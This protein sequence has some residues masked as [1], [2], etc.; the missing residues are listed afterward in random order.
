MPQEPQ[1][2]CSDW[3]IKRVNWVRVPIITFILSEIRL[4][5]MRHTSVASASAGPNTNIPQTLSIIN[6]IPR[7]HFIHWRFHCET[8]SPCNSCTAQW[9]GTTPIYILYLYK[10]CVCVCVCAVHISCNFHTRTGKRHSKDTYPVSLVQ[11]FVWH[12]VGVLQTALLCT[13]SQ[14]E[15]A[16]KLALENADVE[17]LHRLL[18]LYT[19]LRRP[20]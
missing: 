15:I 2:F 17:Y 13:H 12:L 16:R 18:D 9:I 14:K 11:G 8:L 1:Q 4:G 6:I 7:M 19:A 10:R 3:S 20:Q 5:R